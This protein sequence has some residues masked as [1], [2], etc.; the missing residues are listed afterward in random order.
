M[1]GE[2]R[3]GTI[4]TTAGREG[5]QPHTGYLTDGQTLM[6]EYPRVTPDGEQMDFVGVMEVR[7]GLIHRHRV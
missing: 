2:G 4:P 5:P 6:W 1:P 3:L 7:N